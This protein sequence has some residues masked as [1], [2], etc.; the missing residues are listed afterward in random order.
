MNVTFIY[1]RK[2]DF[3][4]CAERTGFC[5]LDHKLSDFNPWF[6]GMGDNTKVFTGACSGLPQLSADM[7]HNYVNCC[8]KYSLYECSLEYLEQNCTFIRS[9][10]FLHMLPKERIYFSLLKCVNRTII[11]SLL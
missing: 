1:R 5:R 6:L 8:N 4:F 2:V 10:N 3:S 9:T 11:L 7:M